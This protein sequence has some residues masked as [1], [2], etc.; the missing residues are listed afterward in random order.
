M[1]RPRCGSVRGMRLPELL[2]AMPEVWPVLLAEHRAD[3]TG[4]CRRCAGATGAAPV[5]PCR[6][7]VLAEQAGRVGPV[8]TAPPSPTVR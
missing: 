4:H 7:R 2:A 3:R 8:A 5:W 6:L 1:H